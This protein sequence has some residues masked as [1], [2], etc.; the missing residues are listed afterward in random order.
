MIYICIYIYLSLFPFVYSLYV[1]AALLPLAYTSHIG[2]PSLP[3]DAAAPLLPNL[4]RPSTALCVSRAL[5]LARH[6]RRGH[7]CG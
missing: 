5:G 3:P 1:C 4:L 6:N 7:S 2:I